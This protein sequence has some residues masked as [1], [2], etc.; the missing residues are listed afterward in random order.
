LINHQYWSSSDSVSNVGHTVAWCDTLGFFV[1]I[2]DR[3]VSG[4][5]NRISTSPDGDV[6]TDRS[7]PWDYN[8]SFDS[9]SFQGMWS[10]MCITWA[11]DLGLIVAGS[12]GS[13]SGAD[14]RY[15][16]MTSTD[17]VTWNQYDPSSGAGNW[18]FSS[19]AWAPSPINLLVAVGSFGGSSFIATSPNGSTWTTRSIPW[20]NGVV[21]DVVWADTLGMLLVTG[22][23]Y[24]GFNQG[25]NTLLTSTDGINWTSRHTPFDR[26]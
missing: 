11:H 17:A 8:G 10:G 25:T 2:A 21:H 22:Y 26:S 1:T 18:T 19:I 4:A 20:S 16:V 24:N 23:D 15:S 7:T 5:T 9:S 6:W 14:H 12:G 3:V 13:H